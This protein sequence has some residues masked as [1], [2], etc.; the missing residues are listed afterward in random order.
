MELQEYRKYKGSQV[1]LLGIGSVRRP[2]G[3]MV[4]CVVGGLVGDEEKCRA[5]CA[6]DILK[7]AAR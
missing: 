3:V 5:G 4:E 1:S 6:M 7:G 2:A